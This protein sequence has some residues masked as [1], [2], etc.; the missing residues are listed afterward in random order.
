MCWACG[1]GKWCWND[2]IAEIK[3]QN[4]THRIPILACL[5]FGKTFVLPTDASDQGLRV[6]FLQNLDEGDHVICY[7]TRVLSK[8][9]KNYSK[10]EKECLAVF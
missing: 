9:E 7:A 5:D 2:K 1:R 6:A 10:T 3:N 8:P 4:Q